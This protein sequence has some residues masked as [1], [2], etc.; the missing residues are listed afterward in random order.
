MINCN[1]ETVSSTLTRQISFTLN[2]YSE[3]I[4]DIIIRHTKPEGVIVQLWTNS[5]KLAEKL[6]R[7]GIKIIGTS[8]DALISQ[9]TAVVFQN[10][11]KKLIFHPPFDIATTDEALKF[12]D[13]LDFPY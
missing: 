1:P 7:Y 6:H 12:A 8:Y 13:K 11:L 10:C 5:L 9:K 3:H 4:Y 2:R